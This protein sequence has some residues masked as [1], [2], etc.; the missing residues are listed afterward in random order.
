MARPDDG[1]ILGLVCATLAVHKRR[2]KT[3][4]MQVALADNGKIVPGGSWPPDRVNSQPP[5]TGGVVELLDQFCRRWFR[6]TRGFIGRQLSGCTEA[7][8]IHDAARE[9]VSGR[10]ETFFHRLVAGDLNVTHVLIVPAGGPLG[11]GGVRY[12]YDAQID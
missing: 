2:S 3:T 9:A 7:T 11:R 10:Y 6:S 4:V 1:S 5:C 8:H 12:P